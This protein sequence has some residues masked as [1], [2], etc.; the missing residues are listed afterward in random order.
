MPS[1]VSS[2]PREG[3]LPPTARPLVETASPALDLAATL[4]FF[5]AAAVF[6]TDAES[7][8][9]ALAAAEGALLVETIGEE[10]DEGRAAAATEGVRRAVRANIRSFD[11]WKGEVEVLRPC[12]FFFFFSFFSCFFFQTESSSVALSFSFARTTMQPSSLRCGAHALMARTRCVCVAP[13]RVVAVG[14]RRQLRAAVLA[15]SAAGGGIGMRRQ[16]SPARP[17]FRAA[18][19]AAPDASSDTVR[20]KNI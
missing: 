17:A 6:F 19:P 16:S 5:A 7:G 20:L 18:S 11:R 4:G 15:S 2:L 9:L 3:N 8:A 1:S 13:A 12:L 14:S 10:R